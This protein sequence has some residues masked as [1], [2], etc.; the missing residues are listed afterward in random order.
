MGD[1]VSIEEIFRVVRAQP[2]DPDREW[3]NETRLRCLDLVQTVQEGG[4]EA[5]VAVLEK[6]RENTRRLVK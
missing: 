4:L 2:E 1:T 5:G 6:H 3:V